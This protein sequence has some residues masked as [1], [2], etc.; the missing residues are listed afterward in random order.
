MHLRSWCKAPR[1]PWIAT[2]RRR[3]REWTRHSN[4]HTQFDDGCPQHLREAIRYSLLAPGKRLR[5]M[6]VLAAAEA[7]GGPIEAALPAACAVEMVHCLFADSR[8]PAGDGRRRPAPRPA[9]LPQGLRRGHGHPGRR[10]AVDPGL[11]SAGPT[12]SP[13]ARWRRECCAVLAEAA[14]APALVGGQADDLAGEFCRTAMAGDASTAIHRRKTGAM[15]L[16]SLQAGGAGGRRPTT[17]NCAALAVYGRA[18]GSGVS[19]RRR[20]AGRARRRRG[21]GQ[22]RGQGFTTAAS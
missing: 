14:G 13:A 11:R 19:D 10:R 9:D 1:F 6:L 22:T 16:A 20:P 21:H 3:A 2:P 17:S 15:F 8:R 5:P 4:E 18:A 7:C 12:S